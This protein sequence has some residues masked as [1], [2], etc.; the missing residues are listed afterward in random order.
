MK[1]I[2]L[3]LIFFCC[4][5]HGFDKTIFLTGPCGFI[6]S[7][8]LIYMF[9]KYPDTRFIVLDAL[10]LKSRNSMYAVGAQL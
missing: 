3:L 8:F 6:G 5:L 9:N 4:N 7:N 1:K 2:F 10:T